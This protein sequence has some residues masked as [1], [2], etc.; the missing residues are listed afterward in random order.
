MTAGILSLNS[1]NQG[2]HTRPVLV[3]HAGCVLNGLPPRIG[4]RS[5]LPPRD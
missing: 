1:V 2:S 4:C 3:R 5:A